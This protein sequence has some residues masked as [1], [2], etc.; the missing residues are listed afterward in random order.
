TKARSHLADLGHESS[1]QRGESKVAFLESHSLLPESEKEVATRVGIDNSLQAYFGR[2]H[3]KR[4]KG[5]DR[6]APCRT[7]KVADYA[8]V[9]IQNFGRRA[10]PSIHGERPR[11]RE[12]RPGRQLNFAGNRGFLRWCCGDWRR[13]GRCRCGR[14]GNPSLGRLKRLNLRLKGA[15]AVLQRP[16]PIPHVFRLCTNQSRPQKDA[17]EKDTGSSHGN[18]LLQSSLNS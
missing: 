18:A 7:D 2:V 12:W 16:E 5:I 14:C 4:R 17:K 3:L 9:G 13:G 8:D 15:D 11:G 10:G 6:V 1:G